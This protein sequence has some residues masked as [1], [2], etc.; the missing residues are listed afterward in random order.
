MPDHQPVLRRRPPRPRRGQT[1]V[2]AALSLLLLALMVAL[3]FNISHA[4]RGKTRL[5]QHSDAM[6]YSLAVLE[7]RTF[8]YFAIGN[9]AIA[10]SY[11]AMNSLHAYMAAASVTS[12]MLRAGQ[13]NLQAIAV[14]E[15]ALCAL[16]LTGDCSH[17]PHAAEAVQVSRRFSSKAEEYDREIKKADRKFTQAV[18]ALDQMM[19]ALH[20]S[21]Q[22]V[23]LETSGALRTGTDAHLT[24]LKQINAPEA[25]DLPGAVGLLNVGELSCA[26][27]GMSCSIPGKPGNASRRTRA[28]L[29]TEVANASRPSWTA[30]R[31]VFVPYYL[32][33]RFLE[34]LMSGIQE[35]GTSIPFSHGGTA[36]TARSLD[37]VEGGPS[38][39]NEG[40]VS[41]AD[42]HGRLLTFWRDGAWVSR[43]QVRL[44]SG[45]SAS[46]HEP[47]G[48]HAEPHDTYEGA[49]VRDLASCAGRGN[50]FMKF[51]ADKEACRDYGQPHVYVYLTQK[52]RVGD[53]QRAPWELNAQARVSFKHGKQGTARVDLAADEGAALSHALVYYHRLGDW[54]EQPNL[55][56]PFWRAKLHPLTPEQ[57][58]RVLTVAGNTDAAWLALSPNLSL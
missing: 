26:L 56:S 23:F 42:E 6:A 55:F 51:R 46:A 14:E 34:D 30:D 53:V 47:R 19:D 54:R 28:L 18:T 29:M 24:L 22:A 16:C 39:D 36:K 12:E 10:A 57:A 9:R 58:S 11:V 8:N 38:R 37:E 2:L 7:A 15:G 41:A 44:A 21:Q 33:P 48:G 1:L 13:R 32:H 35:Q 49:H 52:L 50:C 40:Q 27:D 3:S 20:A 31:G 17:C 43:Y 45:K 4:L 25:S 5:Q